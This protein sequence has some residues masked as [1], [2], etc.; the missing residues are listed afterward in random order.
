MVGKTLHSYLIQ[1]RLGAGGMG[2]V[3]GALDSRL[4]RRVAIKVLPSAALSSADRKR[5]FAQEAKAASALNHPNI[6][7]IYEI[8]NGE[9]DGEPVHY[10]AMELVPGETLDRVIGH[11]GL[12]VRDALKFA[13]QIADA[14]AAAHAAGV[15]HRDLKPSNVMVTPQGVV[16][17]LDFGLAKLAEPADADPYADTLHDEGAPLTEEGTVLGT[18]AYMS[19]EQAEGAKMDGR[20]DIFSFGSLLHEM[21]TGR[22]TFSGRSKL[23]A[24]SAIL[25]QDPQPLSEVVPG[26]PLELDKIVGRCLKKDP[27]RRWQFMADLKVALEELQQELESSQISTVKPMASKSGVST[28]WRRLALG[29][30]V[31]AL[32]GAGSAAWLLRQAL[33]PAPA[34]FQRLTFRRGDITSANSGPDGNVIYSAEWDGAPSTLYSVRPGD[35]E[36]RALGLP[37]GRILSISRSGEM[38]LLLGDGLPGTLARAP[39]GGGAP[40]EILENVTGADWG[41]DGETIAAVRLE[42]GKARLE[43]PIGTVLYRT[44][45]PR[46]EAPEV[47]PDGKLVAFLDLDAVVG[48]YVLCVVGKDHPRQVISKGWRGTG[49]LGWSAGGDEIWL[50][51]TQAGREMALFAVSLSGRQRLVSQ[52]AGTMM[53]QDRTHDGRL[54]VSSVNSRIGIVFDSAGQKARELAWMN[55]SMPY[56]LSDDGSLLLFAALSYSQGRNSAIYVRKTDG[57]PAVRV[58]WGTRPALSPDGKWVAC[59]HHRQTGSEVLF[60][61]TGAGESLTASAEGMRYEAVEWFPDGKRVLIAAAA[62]DKPMR[63][64]VAGVEGGGIRPFAPD[65]VRATRI[66]P[67]G[68]SY[69]VASSGALQLQ[70]IAGGAPRILCRLDADESPIRWS[71]DGQHIFLR[72]TERREMRISRMAV[73]TGRKEA[74]RTVTVPEVGAVFFGRAVMSADGKALACSFQH[75]MADLYLAAGLK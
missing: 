23:S 3:Y 48:D 21:I 4:D 46:P 59:I 47:S 14:L 13:I 35:R 44:D 75:D 30:L 62:G 12:R 57:S 37:A 58:G 56:G 41:P 26:V 20:S 10:I 11:K 28:P 74:W 61:P 54:L 34:S 50:T 8:N 70:P 27:D 39:M 16:K 63:A 7:T 43:Y 18:V 15:L 67:D 19:P 6:V 22:Q 42:D 1:D 40:R 38:L 65:G 9:V 60:L 45:G 17:L 33:Q 68:L 25:H 29:V 32:V 31:G 51:G 49:R 53:L 72:R 55:S 66:S 71:G 2:I 52:L 24:L 36:S 64:W 73:A 5:R 69:L